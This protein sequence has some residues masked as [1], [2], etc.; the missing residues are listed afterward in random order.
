MLAPFAWIYGKIADVRNSLYERGVLH[1]HALGAKTISIGNITAG[2]T[3]KTPLVA[4]VSEML[5]EKGEIVCILTR[6]YGRRDPKKRVLVSD[7]QSVLVN[8]DIGGDE[9]VELANKLLGRA[10]VLADAD[11]VGAAKWAKDAFDVTVFLLDDGFQHRRARRDVDI[12]CI[13]AG[14]PFSSG[15][16]LPA[17]RL[18]ELPH[19]L[20][21]ADAVVITR[22]DM[23]GNISDL[24]SRIEDLA[25]SAAI[26][27]AK[28]E[29]ENVFPLENSSSS[30]RS[31]EL[32]KAARVAAFCGLGNPENFFAL[33]AREFEIVH[34][35][36]YPDHYSYTQSDIKDLEQ[37]AREAGAAALITTG[38]D[39]VKLAQLRFSLSC[40]VA[41]I[42]TVLHDEQ[43]FRAML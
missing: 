12:V 30:D 27:T 35:T 18:R 20:S 19:N 22:A 3:G 25:P 28:N 33:I 42:R 41:E 34:K 29:I 15:K 4:L 8:A 31:A 16:M 5:A 39:A 6:G 23:A 13:D 1:T 26:F 38:K 36:S 14:D 17:G 40:Y 7:W 32:P 2:G 37:H 43:A 24:R 21:R 9:P 11:R 10:V